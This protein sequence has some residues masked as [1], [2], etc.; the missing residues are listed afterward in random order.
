MKIVFAVFL[1][2]C[3]FTLA[4]SGG[5]GEV[6][7][8]GEADDEIHDILSSVK[9]QVEAKTG[10]KYDVFKAISYGTQVV[11]GTNYFVKVHTGDASYIHVRI[12]SAPW[13]QTVPEVSAVETD[14][15]ASDPVEYFDEKSD[16]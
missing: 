15:S 9:D 14:H 6:K 13:Q 8:A 12:Y 1:L 10:K 4:I 11:A 7:G 16:L 5:L 3:A 2:F